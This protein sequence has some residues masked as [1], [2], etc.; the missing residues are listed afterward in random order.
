[1]SRVF[2]LVSKATLE[3]A[4]MAV[5][6]AKG[7]VKDNL[8]FTVWWRGMRRD[9]WLEESCLYIGLYKATLELAAMAVAVAVAKGDVNDNLYFTVWCWVIQA[10]NSNKAWQ[11]FAKSDKLQ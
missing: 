9:L 1:M 7:V 3:L 11:L 10:V 8:Y 4:A 6:V 5:A 2:S